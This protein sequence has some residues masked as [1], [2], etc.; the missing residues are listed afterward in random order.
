[1]VVCRSGRQGL[2]L[3][4]RQGNIGIGHHTTGSFRTASVALPF[5][6]FAEL[7]NAGKVVALEQTAPFK[8]RASWQRDEGPCVLDFDTADPSSLPPGPEPARNGVR[9]ES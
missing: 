4:C 8:G 9:L 2:T 3:C 7:E 6:K 1:M 5:S